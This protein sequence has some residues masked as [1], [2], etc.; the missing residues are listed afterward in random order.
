MTGHAPSVSGHPAA[1]MLQGYG[2]GM[3]RR[4]STSDGGRPVLFLDTPTPDLGP[5]ELDEPAA[6]HQR[7][8]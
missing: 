5:D 6:Q 3:A 8:W 1:S 7:T 2:K 4:S